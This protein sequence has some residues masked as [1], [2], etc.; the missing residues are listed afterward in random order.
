V[1]IVKLLD[2]ANRNG[3]FAKIH[4]TAAS[5]DMSSTL[6]TAATTLHNR[7]SERRRNEIE[8]LLGVITPLFGE[9]SPLFLPIRETLVV[10][11]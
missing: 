5:L 4:A 11:K 3:S 2:E 8:L 10:N 7:R 9:P 1:R 6:C